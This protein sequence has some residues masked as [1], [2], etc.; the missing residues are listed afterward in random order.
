MKVNYSEPDYQ[1]FLKKLDFSKDEWDEIM[2]REPI[3]HIN[4]PNEVNLLRFVNLFVQ[5]IL[6][7]RSYFKN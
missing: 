6:K 4:Y 2:S 5:P 1:D 7:L 3:P